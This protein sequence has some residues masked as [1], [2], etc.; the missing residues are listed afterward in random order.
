MKGCRPLTEEEVDA[1]AASFTGQFA[2]RDRALFVLGIKSGFRISELLSLRV[3][4]VRQ[5]GQFTA[6]VYVERRSTKGKV[7]GRAHEA[8]RLAPPLVITE[9]LIEQAL[10]ILEESVAAAEAA[11]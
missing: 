5:G 9:E 1:V 4:D 6:R 7:E 2:T 3:G 11:R 8:F 10:H